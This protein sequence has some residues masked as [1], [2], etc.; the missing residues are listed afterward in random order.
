VVVVDGAAKQLV[1]HVQTGGAPRKFHLD[2]ASNKLYCL[3]NDA[4]D[5]AVI[6]CR[7]MTLQAKVRLAHW[8][9]GLAFDSIANRLWVTSPDYGC[10]S[11]VDGR[12]NHFLS[13]LEAGDTPGD[14]TWAPQHRKMYI[15][16]ESGEAVLVLRDTSLAGVYENPVSSPVHC[17][18]TIVHGVLFLPN[19]ASPSSSASFLMDVSGRKAL[20][21]K[22]G[23]NDVRRLA[24]GVYFVREAASGERSAV[25]V[26]KVVI[27]R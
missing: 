10:I 25:S 11:L 24:P 12:T 9:T 19:S 8:P 27:T 21:L 15:V 22:P 16:D 14:I 20:D 18:P 7:D 3:L 13:L 6:D 2:R 4:D 17:M 5:V 23:P 26:R 1:G